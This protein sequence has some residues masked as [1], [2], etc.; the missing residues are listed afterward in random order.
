MKVGKLGRGFRGDCRLRL[1]SSGCFG[2]IYD[3][4]TAIGRRCALANASRCL[5][6]PEEAIDGDGLAMVYLRA[7]PVEGADGPDRVR[8]DCSPRPVPKDKLASCILRRVGGPPGAIVQR[9]PLGRHA[10]V[11]QCLFDFRLEP[12]LQFPGS[13]AVLSTALTTGSAAAAS[14][15]LSRPGARAR[16]LGVHAFRIVFE[17]AIALS[18]PLAR[19][20]PNACTHGVKL[21]E[22]QA[23]V[24]SPG[25]VHGT[26]PRNQRPRGS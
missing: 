5:E 17:R 8:A 24:A 20:R 25:N 23:G 3:P 12:R 22:S 2:R 7:F 4:W 26:S 11:Q 21:C 16:S 9:R 18:M 10:C 6:G 13:G 19:S 14:E 15:A 1:G